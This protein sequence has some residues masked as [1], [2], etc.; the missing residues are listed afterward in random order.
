MKRDMD[1]IRAILMAIEEMPTPRPRQTDFK[2]DGYDPEIVSYHVF[3]LN[4]AGLIQAS[5]V[6]HNLAFA[7]APKRLTWAGHE[8]LDAARNDNI[9]AAAKKVCGGAGSLSFDVLKGI[10]VKLGTAAAQQFVVQP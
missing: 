7:W 6:S 1:L 4:D 5:D 8:F 3:L 2:L 10:L 9:W